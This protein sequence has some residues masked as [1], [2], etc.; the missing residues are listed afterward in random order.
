MDEKHSIK[1]FWERKK[2]KILGLM[3]D[4]ETQIYHLEKI[5][6]Q[7]SIERWLMSSSIA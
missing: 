3:A 5:N 6:A 7:N 4:K 2:K 1:K